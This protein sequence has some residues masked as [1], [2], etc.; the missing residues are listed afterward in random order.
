MHMWYFRFGEAQVEVWRFGQANMTKAMEMGRPRTETADKSADF[1]PRGHCWSGLAAD[2][3]RGPSLSAVDIKTKLP[4]CSW[5]KPGFG[6]AQVEV[7]RF[8]QANM[9]KAMEMGRPRTETAD[10]MDCRHKL[11]TGAVRGFQPERSLLE[12]IGRGPR[13]RTE[14]VRG[15]YQDQVTHLFLGQTRVCRVDPMR[16]LSYCK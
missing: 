1:N 12:W 14:P 4:I 5:V 6:E 8:G 9:T 2:H 10:K 3:G 16:I 13:P 11:R 7:W 15:R